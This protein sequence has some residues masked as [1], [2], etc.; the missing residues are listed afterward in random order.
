M[1]L[2]NKWVY[3]KHVIEKKWYNVIY[4]SIL[5]LKKEISVL[6]SPIEMVILD[7]ENEIVVK[8]IRLIYSIYK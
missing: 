7:K 6:I 4:T 8:V 1:P 2:L 5:L 3:W